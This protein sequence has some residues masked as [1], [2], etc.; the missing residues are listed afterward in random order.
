MRRAGVQSFCNAISSALSQHQGAKSQQLV[1]LAEFSVGQLRA[2]GS[3]GAASSMARSFHMPATATSKQTA[4]LS[5]ITC[6]FASQHAAG[7]IAVHAVRHSGCG[8]ASAAN[9]T[10]QHHSSVSA[11][12]HQQ[13][14]TAASRG[15]TAAAAR[16]CVRQPAARTLPGISGMASSRLGLSP[17]ARG[18]ATRA[19]RGRQAGG[20]GGWRDSPT[21][22][23][24][25]LV[26]MSYP[27]CKRHHDMVPETSFSSPCCCCCLCLAQVDHVQVQTFRL[28]SA[29]STGH[30]VLKLQTY[31][32]PSPLPWW[33][34]R[35]P[36]CRSTAC[37]AR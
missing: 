2:V 11:M 37:S 5:P 16:S 9:H 25:Y 23:A 18:L 7:G 29:C 30:E 22:Q 24:T 20:S 13:S 10:A 4:A 17:A 28:L 31:R 8:S 15:F 36:P 3:V 26:S 12:Q 21:Q 35:T 33:A 32:W 1:S 34:S 27:A 6:Q 14:W 19:A